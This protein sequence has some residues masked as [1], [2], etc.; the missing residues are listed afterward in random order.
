MTVDRIVVSMKGANRFGKGQAY[1]AFSRVKTLDGL[2][3]TDFDH[4]GIR[5]D[6]KVEKVMEEMCQKLLP[7]Q[8]ELKLKNCCGP[9]WISVGHL[10]IRYFLPK[11]NDLN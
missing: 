5:A 4:K 9:E 1:V 7:M 6:Q 3:I 10:N 2:Y 11:M 8:S